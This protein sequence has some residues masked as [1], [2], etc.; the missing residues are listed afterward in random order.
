MS[1]ANKKKRYAV[2][3]WTYID[4]IPELFIEE[5]DDLDEAL[6]YAR[7]VKKEFGR[8]VLVVDAYDLEENSDK[9]EGVNSN[10]QSR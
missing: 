7:L 8:K 10:D 5:F 4:D 2:L 6:D 1:C 9:C 3:S